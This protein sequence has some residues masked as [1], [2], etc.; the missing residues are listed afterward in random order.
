MNLRPRSFALPDADRMARQ[1][2]LGRIGFAAAFLTAP[3]PAL[4]SLGADTAT[5]QR[6]S[7]LN[8]MMAVRDGA[9]AVGAL[10]ADRT[11]GD[12]RP[13]LV[14]GAVSDAVD[15][16]AFAEALKQGRL[17][18]IAPPVIAPGALVV[19]GLGLSTAA[20]LRRK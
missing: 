3:V 12:P 16:L 19:A 15:A 7:W 14:A 8:R 9:L 20:R 4:R 11:G 13:W 2:A 18:G 1:L 17:K 6:V 10:V 5:A